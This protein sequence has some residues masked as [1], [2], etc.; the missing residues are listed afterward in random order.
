MGPRFTCPQGHQWEGVSVKPAEA[1]QNVCPTCGAEPGASDEIKQAPAMSPVPVA[2]AV[3]YPTIVVNPE[4]ASSLPKSN[5]NKQVPEHSW[6]TFTTA[7]FVI[8][9]VTLLLGVAGWHLYRSAETEHAEAIANVFME[10]YLNNAESMYD[11]GTRDFQARKGVPANPGYKNWFIDPQERSLSARLDE[12]V[13]RGSLSVP[14]GNPQAGQLKMVTFTL[15]LE[16][17]DGK[18]RIQHFQVRQGK[19]GMGSREN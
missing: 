15:V 1:K 13:F 6:V 2:A 19:E 9:L 5:V 16:K 12:A 10:S 11:I 18:W 4:K 3:T 8:C 14:K 17:E 7:T